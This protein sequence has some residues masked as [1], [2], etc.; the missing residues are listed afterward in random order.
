MSELP[1]RFF[2]AEI[3]RKHVFLQYRQEVPYGVTGGWVLVLC[4]RAVGLGPWPLC[5][6]ALTLIT[7]EQALAA[8]LP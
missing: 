7:A 4:G 1:E 2:V 8:F 5:L 3:I 6:C